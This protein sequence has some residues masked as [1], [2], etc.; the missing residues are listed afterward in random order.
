MDTTNNMMETNDSQWHLM[1][2]DQLLAS[3]REIRKAKI[4][5]NNLCEKLNFKRSNIYRMESGTIDVKVSTLIHY[6]HGFGY[7]LEIV[8]DEEPSK[9]TSKKP[10][11]DYLLETNKININIENYSAKKQRLSKKQRLDLL[12]LL[13]EQYE[14]DLEIEEHNGL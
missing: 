7:H 13:L 6:L 14:E 11:C 2:Y 10:P 8:E 9:E 12:K 3:A 4:S 1:T 5:V